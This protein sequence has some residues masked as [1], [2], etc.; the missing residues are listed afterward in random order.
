MNLHFGGDLDGHKHV[1][2]LWFGVSC[3]TKPK[4]DSLCSVLAREVYFILFVLLV[5]V[6]NEKPLMSQNSEVAVYSCVL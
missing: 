1:P 3:L 6:F 5:I 4:T 2:E